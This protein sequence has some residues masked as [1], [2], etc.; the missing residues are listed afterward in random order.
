MAEKARR[1][2]RAA[3]GLGLSL[4]CRVLV[5][6]LGWQVACAPAMAQDGARPGQSCEAPAE[7]LAAPAPLPRVAAA[8]KKSEKLNILIIGSPIGLARSQSKS[9]PVA[10]ESLLERALTGVDVVIV[11]RPVSGEIVAT[12]AERMRTEVALARPDLLI[13]QVGANDALQNVSPVEYEEHLR[14]GVRWAKENGL[15][16]LLVGFE[17]NPWLHEDR[18]AEAIRAATL[19]VAQAENVLYLRRYEAMQFAARARGRAE[20]GDRPFSADVG[21]DCLAE[22]V[23]QALVANM[24]LRRTRPGVVD[25]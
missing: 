16:V 13:W 10:L 5:F 18:E 12:A 25:P 8:L 6:L 20:Q 11:N 23:A 14:E 2:A 17:A 21:Y 1:G 22:Q 19:R 15:D 9:Y 7:S 3:P 4:A 24:V